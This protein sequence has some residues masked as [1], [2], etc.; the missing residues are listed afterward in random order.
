MTPIV[1]RVH[2]SENETLKDNFSFAFGI[3][4]LAQF[5]LAGYGFEVKPPLQESLSIADFIS[6]ANVPGG[7]SRGIVIFCQ[8]SRL[9]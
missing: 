5:V 6:K 3:K 9:E 4:L 8:S 1:L 7:L 2:I